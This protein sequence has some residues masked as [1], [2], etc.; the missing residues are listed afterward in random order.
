MDQKWDT[1]S[2][3]GQLEKNEK[4]ENFKSENLKLEIF[5]SNWKVLI[6]VGKFSMQ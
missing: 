5:P 2:W 1:S 3:K 4:L 6:E